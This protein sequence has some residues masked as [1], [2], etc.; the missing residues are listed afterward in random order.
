MVDIPYADQRD[1]FDPDQ[2][3]RPVHLI[4]LGGIGSAVVLPLIKL[5]LKS[6]LHLWDPDIVEPHNIPCQLIYGTAD[7][8]TSKV[9]ATAALMAQLGAQCDIAQHPEVVTEATPLEGIVISG[10]DSMK[11]RRAIWEAVQGSL[12]VELYMDGRI[13]GEQ[14]QLHTLD[15]LD[16]DYAETYEGTWLFDDGE[17]SPLPCTARTVIH[18]AVVLAGLM[19]NQLTRFARQLEL[20]RLILAD[21]SATDIQP[22]PQP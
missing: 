19:V 3:T 2:F 4:G 9:A 8:G 10:V 6:T 22:Q 20:K 15:P 16:Y 12:D 11:S 17:A 13:G 18:P 5:G 1:F 14:F 7:I 21:M